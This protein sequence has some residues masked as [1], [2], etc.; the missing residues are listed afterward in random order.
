M[1]HSSWVRGLKHHLGD[2]LIA[3][4]R[5]T[6][7]ECV[8][9]NKRAQ[10]E[11]KDQ[12][13]SHSSW[14]RGLKQLVAIEQRR[15]AMSHSSWVRGL[16]PAR[17]DQRKR[18]RGR[19]LRE[20]VDWNIILAIYSSHITVALFVSA[21]IETPYTAYACRWSWSHSS[22]VRGLKHNVYCLV[23][24]TDQS[25]SSWVRGL[26]PSGTQFL[27]GRHWVALFVSAWIETV[28]RRQSI[29]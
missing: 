3:H 17:M 8:D 22:W 2:I 16:K 20:C 6:L 4:Y 10:E 19:T 9:W 24:Y 14:V 13:K 18:R 1:S 5:R 11:A 25:H 12:V 21:W 15:R 28:F 23:I 29:W 7:R 27:D 26:K